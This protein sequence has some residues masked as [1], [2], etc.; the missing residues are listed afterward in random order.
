MD[1]LND[2]PYESFLSLK[3]NVNFRKLIAGKNEKKI[4]TIGSTI[5]TLVYRPSGK[6]TSER[7]QIFPEETILEP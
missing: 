3:K 5:G 4:D 7:E 6:V 2:S 1:P